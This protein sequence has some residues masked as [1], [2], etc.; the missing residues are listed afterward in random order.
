[1]S[2]DTG[3]E[4]TE[5]KPEGEA[6]TPEG[7]KP[8]GDKPKGEDASSKAT[9]SGISTLEDAQK[10]IA[11]LRKENA[12]K[13][14]KAREVEDKAKKWEEHV[15]SQKTE[16]EKLQERLNEL[17]TNNGR[18]KLEKLQVDLAKKHGVDLDLSDL[19]V[20]SDEEAMEEAAKRLAAKTVKAKKTTATDLRAGQ[21]GRVDGESASTWFADLFDANK[22]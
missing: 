4:S 13:R 3:Q 1:M 16:M 17:E 18:Y 14:T 19:I 2:E 6:T 21:Q 9:E 22:T 8:E 7:D 15:N 20:G 10:E 12:S 11:K 5:G